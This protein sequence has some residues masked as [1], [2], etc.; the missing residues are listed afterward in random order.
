MSASE[1]R[2]SSTS[3]VFY[4]LPET[5]LGF[6][7]LAPYLV[8]SPFLI[9]PARVGLLEDIEFVS[10]ALVLGEKPATFPSEAVEFVTLDHSKFR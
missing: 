4:V 10:S 3:V 8:V 7:Q 1:A 2:H 5:F 9:M 6:I